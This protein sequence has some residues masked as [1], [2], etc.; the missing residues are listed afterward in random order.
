M[1][2][3]LLPEAKLADRPEGLAAQ[4]VVRAPRRRLEL[5]VPLGAE[6]RELTLVPGLPRERVGSRRCLGE[7][8]QTAENDRAAGPT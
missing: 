4:A 7:L 1:Q 5:V 3:E 2:L 8:H 6:G